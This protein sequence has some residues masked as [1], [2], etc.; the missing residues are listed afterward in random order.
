MQRMFG[1]SFSAF[2][3][4]PVATGETW[5]NTSEIVQPAI[6]TLNTVRTSTLQAVDTTGGS[7]M[8]RIGIVVAIKQSAE[9]PAAGAPMKMTMGDA[10]G[11]GE[12]TF[13]VTNGRIQRT[14]VDMD[15][16]MTMAATMPDG[17]FMSIQNSV[18]TTMVMELVR[19]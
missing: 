17:E 1:Q 10:S 2:P 13:D 19:R 16:P 14:T 18:H 3:D 12:I 7:A 5:T 15:M 11:T 4:A 6:G 9:A 8:A